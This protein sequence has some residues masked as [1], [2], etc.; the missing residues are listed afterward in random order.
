MTRW[1]RWAGLAVVLTAAAVLSFDALR[2]LALAVAI[3]ATLAWLL[4]VAVDAGA[5]VSC[6]CWLARDVPPDAA[7]FARAQTW[8]LLAGTVAGN[9]AQLGMHAAGLV[10]PW[11]VAVLVGAVPPAVVGGT[12]HLAVLVGRPATAPRA[13]TV[14]DRSPTR[15]INL[16]ASDEEIIADVREWSADRGR[17]P[18]RDDMIAAYGIGASRATKLRR[19]LAWADSPTGDPTAPT[20]GAVG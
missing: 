13:A 6:A 12:V 16:P 19:Y 18:S 1:I 4:P 20:A 7:R 11:W 3:P 15:P 9:A 17:P 14:A 10:P 8:L 5:A 2:A